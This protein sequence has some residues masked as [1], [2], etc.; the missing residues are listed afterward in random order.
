ML[1][2][3]GQQHLYSVSGLPFFKVSNVSSTVINF[4]RTG[5]LPD[6]VWISEHILDDS[7]QL[8]YL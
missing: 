8:F 4:N 6:F 1:Y 5:D 7:L 2:T 3:K